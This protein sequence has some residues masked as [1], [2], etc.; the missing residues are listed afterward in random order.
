MK[1]DEEG[2]ETAGSTNQVSYVRIPFGA[3]Y[4]HVRLEVCTRLG[5]TADFKTIGLG[6]ACFNLSEIRVFESWLDEAGS[7]NNGV[8]ADV[9]KAF[10]DAMAKA[11]AELATES[12]TQATIDELTKAHANYLDVF[13]DPQQAVNALNNA[14]ARVKAAVEGT[15]PVLLRRRRQGSYHERSRCY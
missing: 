4:Q 3:D 14:K 13:P 15:D 9:L 7:L 12:A 10:T 8:P 5:S 6:S 11:E 1:V 2:N